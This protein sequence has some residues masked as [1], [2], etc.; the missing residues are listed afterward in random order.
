MPSITFWKAVV[1][2]SCRESLATDFQL[3]KAKLLWVTGPDTCP[4]WN[5]PSV[6]QQSIHLLMRWVPECPTYLGGKPRC[7]SATWFTL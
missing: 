5:S 6:G 1:T 7:I 3:P 4:C 2:Q